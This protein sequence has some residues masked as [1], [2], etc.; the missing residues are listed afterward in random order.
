MLSRELIVDACGVINLIA[1]G[2][3]QSCLEP[4]DP[5]AQVT[6]ATEGECQGK[7]YTARVLRL[8]IEAALLELSEI[9]ITADDLTSF[10]TEHQLGA[11]ESE[12]ILTCRAVQKHFW[13]DDRK[14]RNVA[15]GLLG[16]DAVTGTIGILRELVSLGEIAADEAFG[17]YAAMRAAGAFL[18]VLEQADFEV[19]RA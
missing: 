9:E 15:R 12:A 14:A 4:I 16:E 13:C 11:G 8:L 3:A 19:E 6:P 7:Q 18:P 2:I 1:G 5:T 17:A 10:M